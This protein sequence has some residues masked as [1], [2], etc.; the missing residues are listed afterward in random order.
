MDKS[1]FDGVKATYHDPCNYGRKSL[2]KFGHAYYEEG[3]KVMDYV[4]NDWIDV[5]PHRGN[6]YCC[7]GGG[8][9]MLTPYVEERT[10]YGERKMAQIKR[11][12]ASLVVVPCHSCHGQ[13]KA[14]AAACG[15]DYLEVKYLWEVTAEALV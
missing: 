5:P 13:L 15:L 4:F 2:E 12:G 6:Q 9:T 8:G 14:M 3:R 7:G 10:L 11:S 1:R